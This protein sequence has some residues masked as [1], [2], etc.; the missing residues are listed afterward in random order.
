MRYAVTLERRPARAASEEPLRR[1]LFQDA[2]SGD[3]AAQAVLG[4][5]AEPDFKVVGVWPAEGA[6]QELPH[7]AVARSVARPRPPGKKKTD[8]RTAP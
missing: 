7:W 1:V 6:A 4:R 5:M 3:A 8:E 2:E